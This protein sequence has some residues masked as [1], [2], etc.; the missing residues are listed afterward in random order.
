M[1]YTAFW[2]FSVGNVEQLNAHP[3]DSILLAFRHIMDDAWHPCAIFEHGNTL[4]R[5]IFTIKL[6]AITELLEAF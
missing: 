1:N 5:H 3:K 2:Q 4:F 6:P